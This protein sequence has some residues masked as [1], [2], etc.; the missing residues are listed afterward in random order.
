MSSLC[1][2]G[3]CCTLE[4]LSVT[5]LSREI[6]CCGCYHMLHY[7]GHCRLHTLLS[8][9]SFAGVSSCL[10]AMLWN[11]MTFDGYQV[12]LGLTLLGSRPPG[13]QPLWGSWTFGSWF[14]FTSLIWLG[15]VWPASAAYAMIIIPVKAPHLLGARFISYAPVK[16]VS[17]R[18]VF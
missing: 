8:L 5:T 14:V 13:G 10:S 6:I 17:G 9:A 2:S 7:F 4:C 1:T 12:V 16:F 15:W 11:M 18:L 3:S